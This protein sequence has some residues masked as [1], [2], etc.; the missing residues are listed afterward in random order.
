MVE[1][2]HQRRALVRWASY[3]SVL[4]AVL[5]LGIKGA[6]YLRTDAVS[7]LTSLVDAAV[8]LGASIATLVGVWYASQP[9]D[10]DHRFGHG[11]G[12]TLAAYMQAI[13]LI[14]AALALVAQS[15]R[16]LAFPQPVNDLDAGLVIVIASLGTALLLV[17]FQSYVL[18]NT[19]S[20]AIEADRAHYR[21]DV[22]VNV[23]V[24]VA[25]GI[26][27][28]TGWL[29]TD[30]AIAFLIALYMLR[31]GMLI[32]RAALRSLL[33]EEL[34]DAQREKIKGIILSNPDVRGVHDLRTRDAGD[35][36][37]IE[38]HLELDGHLSIAE[39]HS[40]TDATEKAVAAAFGNADVLAHQEP[41]GID[42]ER[43][44]DA[45]QAQAQA[46]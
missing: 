10:A 33:D 19:G 46:R 2:L 25:L 30:P 37:V 34:S 18:R 12:E 43:L 21:A 38:Y 1:D 39:G 3:A 24:L 29:R 41:A 32:A 40:I 15:I 42:D 26:T 22:L 9:A 4:I 36:V 11:K 7:L 14:V 35:R 6:A 27:R 17:A 23:G 13:F 28:M 8:D 20:A 5:L 44:D 16:R 31:N 45:V